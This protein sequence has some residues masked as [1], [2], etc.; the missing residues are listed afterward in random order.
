MTTH[1]KKKKTK[2]PKHK[3]TKKSNARDAVRCWVYIN[4][5]LASAVIELAGFLCCSLF[6]ALDSP[7]AHPLLPLTSA[8]AGLQPKNVNAVGL[9]LLFLWTVSEVLKWKNLFLGI[10]PTQV[11]ES[12]IL[13][14]ACLLGSFS[15]AELEFQNMCQSCVPGY[16]LEEMWGGKVHGW[17]F[18]I[19]KRAVHH[20]CV[21]IAALTW[22]ASANI[23]VPQLES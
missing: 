10:L 9:G 14:D 5:C 12:I 6:T 11:Y 4:K 7:S 17:D 16:W 20:R 3:P 15:E 23:K 2:K 13:N 22:C 19:G 1:V 21:I 18:R 8:G